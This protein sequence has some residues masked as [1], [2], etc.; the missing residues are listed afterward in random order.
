MNKFELLIDTLAKAAGSEIVKSR[1]AHGQDEVRNAAVTGARIA[2]NARAQIEEETK[3]SIITRD[4]TMENP[5]DRKKL[6]KL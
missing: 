4:R 1:D 3:Q 6:K 5:V 2:G